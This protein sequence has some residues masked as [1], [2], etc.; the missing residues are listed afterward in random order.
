MNISLI[1]D[2]SLTMSQVCYNNQSILDNVKNG[3]EYFLKNKIKQYDRLKY[4]TLHLYCTSESQPLSSYAHDYTHLFYQLR[5]I[6]SQISTN[7][8]ETL[9]QCYENLSLFRILNGSDFILGGRDIY[10]LDPGLVLLFTDQQDPLQLKMMEDIILSSKVNNRW[11]QNLII[12]YMSLPGQLEKSQQD[13]SQQL[14]VLQSHAQFQMYQR[15]SY[16]LNGSTFI[17]NSYE[18]IFNAFEEVLNNYQIKL[19]FILENSKILLNDS[20]AK[21]FA[22]FPQI[23]N[24][25][26]LPHEDYLKPNQYLVQSPCRIQNSYIQVKNRAEPNLQSFAKVVLPS[27]P[28]DV[29]D[30]NQKSAK[31]DRYPVFYCDLTLIYYQ[32]NKMVQD[33]P[34]ERIDVYSCFLN[35]YFQQNI[36]SKDAL[37]YFPLFA[38]GNT[39]V[40]LMK[41]K[42]QEDNVKMELQYFY[43]DFIL[44]QDIFAKI[45]Y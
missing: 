11:D 28:I 5:N 24:P 40:G 27:R 10:K 19:G 2:N 37:Y 8:A 34:C 13:P 14:Q 33:F 9:L 25:K 39:L 21:Y 12:F 1:V 26:Q 32:Q 31:L 20:Y 44:F 23:Y 35:Q 7:T 18:A 22:E 30:P 4:E 41:V 15:I 17:I 29:N 45:K 36:N 3:I 42:K 16:Y 38:E 6:Q 43:W